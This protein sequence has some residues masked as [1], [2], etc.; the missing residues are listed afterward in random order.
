MCLSHFGLADRLDVLR[1]LLID[2][3]CWTTQVV[4]EELKQASAGAPALIDEAL[5][6][7]LK[8][9]RLDTLDEIRL[10]A[11]WVGRLGDRLLPSMQPA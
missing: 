4:I 6:D 2:K 7:W 3:E 11:L 5:N 8:I 9:A 10:F 1:G